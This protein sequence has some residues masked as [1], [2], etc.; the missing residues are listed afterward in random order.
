MI[1]N[2]SGVSWFEDNNNLPNKEKIIALKKSS[3][4][5]EIDFDSKTYKIKSYCAFP[6]H[7]PSGEIEGFI[8]LINKRISEDNILTKH[9]DIDN[10]VSKFS[11][12]DL[13]LLESFTNQAGISLEHSKLIND[14]KKAFESFTAASIIAIE[15]RDPTTKGHSER[16]ATLTVGL[17]EAIN[18]TKNGVYSSLE[19]S[20][21]QVEE[22]RYASLLHDFGKIGVREHILNKEKKLFPYQ[23]EKIQSRFLMLQD[24]LHINILEKYISNLM[25]KKEI[26][27]QEELE[28]H[29][30]EILN[31]ST[32]F[33]K[34]FDVILDVNEPALLSQ[35]FF[36]KISEIAATKIIVGDNSYSLLSEKEIEILSIKKGSL[37]Q[38]ERLEIES[39]V[40]HSYNFLIQIPWSN[41]LRDIPEIVYGHHE[42]LDGSGYPRNLKGKNIP[43][44]AKMMAITDIF[45]A[46]VAQDRPYKKAIPY[47]RALNILEAEVKHGKLDGDLFKIF[48]EARVGHLILNQNAEKETKNSSVA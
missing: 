26:P 3:P 5:P 46:L 30:E 14:L 2:K 4:L 9:S 23:L 43:V 45:D 28:K 36:D 42:R 10:Y 31:I 19:F 33:T 48:V 18:N 27:K 21:I 35:E 20:K 39:H 38:A 25:A 24:K 1:E 37:S 29:K 32:K 6:I 15:S 12:H 44:Q 40:T 13:N 41:E 47:E 7:L 22:I 17:A 16:V 11:S 8:I 34:Y